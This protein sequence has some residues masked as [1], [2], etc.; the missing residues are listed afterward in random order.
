MHSKKII[1]ALL[2]TVA[3]HVYAEPAAQ[4]GDSVDSLAGVK[5]MTTVNGQSGSLAERMA[6]NA[7]Q[8]SVS[9]TQQPV[10]ETVSVEA[11]DTPIAQ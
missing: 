10:D 6:T 2:C 1:V 7:S 9:A 4:S 3:A 11:I 5:I 8:A